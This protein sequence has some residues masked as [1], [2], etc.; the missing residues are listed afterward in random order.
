MTYQ[1]ELIFG[2]SRWINKTIIY[3]DNKSSEEFFNDDKTFDACCYCLLVISE[4]G[5]KLKD[6]DE[7]KNKFSNIN[8][9]EIASIYS[10]CLDGDNINLS[11][12]YDVISKAFPAL[13]KELNK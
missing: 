9:K 1:E 7:I 13:L 6:N 12:I 2:L 10:K 4:I 8:F 3:L 11:L 5:E